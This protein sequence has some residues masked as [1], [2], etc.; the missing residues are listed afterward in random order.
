MDGRQREKFALVFVDVW[1]GVWFQ[2]HQKVVLYLLGL[3]LIE[4]VKP[5][6]PSSV[7]S[8]QFITKDI[9]FQEKNKKDSRF[10]PNKN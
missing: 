2:N 1:F 10:Y 9:R 3:F 7:A 5:F 8:K 4:T 6:R